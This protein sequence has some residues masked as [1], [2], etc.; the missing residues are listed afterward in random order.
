IGNFVYSGTEERNGYISPGHNS[1]YFDEETGQ[2]Y[3]IFHTRFP[4]NGEYHSVRVHQMFFTETGWP[5]IAP[6]R[7]A[8]E[9]IDDYTPA[10]VVG[11]YSALIFNK[12]ISDEASTPQVIKLSKN[13]QIT[14][15][16]SGNWKIADENSQYDAEVEISEVVYKGKFISCWD[17]NQ[18]KQVMTFTGTSESG[19]PLFIVKNEG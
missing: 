18:H 12:L 14:G 17:E 1:T 16:L 11:D 3:M 13:G 5:V 9:V 2:Y 4:D 15:D 6:L 8:G 10:Q 19:I 7:Y